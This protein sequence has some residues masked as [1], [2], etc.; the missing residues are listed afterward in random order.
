MAGLSP[1]SRASSAPSRRRAAFS[2]LS[3]AA[4]RRLRLR[5]AAT[6][7]VATSRALDQGL[8]TKS[9]APARMAA[10]ATLTPL[11]PVATTTTASGSC[12]RSSARSAS[13]SS[14][15]AAPRRKLRSSST[16][17]GGPAARALHASAGLSAASTAK[18]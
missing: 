18:P 10:T 11:W 16:T 9:V 3:P 14:P 5:A 17:S 6:C 8:V 4:S 7:R 12:A 1:I 13:P 2:R 15:D